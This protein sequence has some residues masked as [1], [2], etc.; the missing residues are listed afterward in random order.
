[1]SIIL[2]TTALIMFLGVSFFYNLA[3]AANTPVKITGKVE[4]IRVPDAGMNFYFLVPK[5]GTQIFLGAPFEV[6]EDPNKECVGK[7]EEN[8]SEVTLEG[9]LIKEGN[10]YSFLEDKYA[11]VQ[12]APS[13]GSGYGPRIFGLQVGMTK[14]EAINIIAQYA[15]KHNIPYDKVKPLL[16]NNGIILEVVFMDSKTANAY[17]I[18][19]QAFNVS[20]MFD[21]SFLQ[22]FV[23]NYNIPELN[24]LEYSSAGVR[25]VK[26]V[27][28]NEEEGFKL[29]IYK[30]Y[31]TVTSIPKKNLANPVFE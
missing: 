18:T 28:K 5:N 6:Q 4:S 9:I 16:Y 11:C 13:T 27:Y 20:T 10:E 21:R 25:E 22:Q 14:P 31:L 19:C 12:A 15:Q 1:M 26:Y 23:D 24:P 8:E 7:A 30:T 29:D 17:M 2:R 3:Y